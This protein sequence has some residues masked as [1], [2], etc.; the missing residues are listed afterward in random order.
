MLAKQFG[1]M[2]CSRLSPLGG[3]ISGFLLVTFVLI[4]TLSFRQRMLPVAVLSVAANRLST[5]QSCTKNLTFW[6]AGLS[7]QNPNPHTVFVVCHIDASSHNCST[8]AKI[9]DLVTNC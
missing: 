3:R 5:S 1:I 2:Q 9:R 7:L 6:H 8:L 4:V